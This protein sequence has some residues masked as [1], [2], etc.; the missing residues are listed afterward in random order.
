MGV[1]LL[2]VDSF[3]SLQQKKVAIYECDEGFRVGEEDTGLQT[4]IRIRM[5]LEDSLGHC[6]LP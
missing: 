6:A 4:H 2:S 3:R 5:K 1:V